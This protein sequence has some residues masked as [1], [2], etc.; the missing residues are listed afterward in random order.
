MNDLLAGYARD[1][2]LLRV[3]RSGDPPGL[4][5]AGEADSSNRHILAG[6]LAALSEEAAGTDERVAVDVAALTFADGAA[7]RLLVRAAVDLPA[8]LCVSGCSPTLRKLL[9][10]V[11]GDGV[12]KLSITDELSIDG[13]LSIDDATGEARS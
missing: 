2:Q 12:A 8:G 4:T 1:D 5:L 10:L 3:I 7:A 9:S 13:T 6:M 11:G